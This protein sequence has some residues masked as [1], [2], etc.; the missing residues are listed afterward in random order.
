[1]Q[2]T[3]TGTNKY[4]FSKLKK[5]A[6]LGIILFLVLSI[7]LYTFL[8]T[9]S[10]YKNM[11]YFVYKFIYVITQRERRNEIMLLDTDKQKFVDDIA[12]YVQKYAG[13]YGIS[14]HSPIIAQAIL[15]SGWG[16]SRLAAD[17][18]NYFG[19]KCGT[20]WT[21]PSVNMTTQEEYTAGTLAT[22]KDNFRVYDNME[23]GVKGYF[24]FIQLSRY[25]NLKGI[26]NPQKYIET[27]KN[28]GYATSSTYVDSL[29]QI[30]KIYNLTSYDSA[31]SVE[32]ED[33]MGSRQAMV[34]KM[35]SWIG[36]NEVDG[37]F[38]EI[39]D[40]YNSHT[41]RAR[42]YKLQYSDE[43][44]AG[45][46]SA[47]AIATGNTNAVPLEVSCHYMIEGAKAK[48]IWVEIDSYVPQG[49][50]IILYDWQD[51][52]IGDNT[53]NPDHVGVVEYTSGGI[54]H[55]I[56][57]NNGEKVAR[58]ELSVN[59]R[60]IRGFIVPKYSNNTA[61][62]GS[63]TP[64]VSGTINELARR[65]I[66]GEFGSG[67]ARKNALGDKYTAVQERVNEI[68]NGT[69]S[70]PSK[71][72]S[73]IAKEVLAGKWGNGADRKNKLTAAGYNYNEVQAVVNSLN[74]KSVT[75]IAKEVIAGKWGNGSD[76]K[77][78][79]ESAGYNYNEVQ[80]EV[81]RLL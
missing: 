57:G 1:M 45:T 27:I 22:N 28:D 72:V 34:A 6:K 38:R 51:S 53:G 79:L 64:T 35:K 2:G 5:G 48:G 7:T 81:N 4:P 39:I 19:M 13:S 46:V 21:G 8:Y 10:D 69:A 54:I 44:C 52:G 11:P 12:K 20:K 33:I 76:R 73:E 14:V 59:G 70:T 74:K 23:N 58:R 16:K 68:L 80:K 75:T 62:G 3:K 78:K 37:S 15:E 61:S 40:I 17:Y 42:G 50:D 71:S 30:I 77:K 9:I 43:W 65:V 31:E 55:V 18:H 26:V 47:A 25:E 41:P 29:M 36:K 67:D 32:G 24:E 49:G 66:A 60:Y 63:S 56:E